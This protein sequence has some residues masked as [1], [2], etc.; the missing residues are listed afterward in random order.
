ML[1]ETVTGSCSPVELPLVGDKES[2]AASSLT[3]HSNVPLP[4]FQMFNVWFAGFAPPAIA[5]KLKLA[6]L[7]AIV[8]SKVM[9]KVTGTV[10]GVLVA[11]VAAMVIVAE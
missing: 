11:P 6:G 4:E 3:D 8:D 9:F 1:T 10:C 2:Q 5:V 7:K